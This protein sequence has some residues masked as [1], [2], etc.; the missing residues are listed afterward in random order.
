MQTE[1]DFKHSIGVFL[2]ELV[3]E[4][5]FS[6]DHVIYAFGLLERYLSKSDLNGNIDLEKLF[7]IAA[8]VAHKFLEEEENWYLPE[9]SIL[10]RLEVEETKM[11]E[12]KFCHG[13]GF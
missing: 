3:E 8:F 9:F 1:R 6:L 12:E 13:V 11:L 2:R 7:S 4:G 5:D 10:A